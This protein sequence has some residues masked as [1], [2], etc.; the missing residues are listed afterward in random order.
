MYVGFMNHGNM[1]QVKRK[2]EHKIFTFFMNFMLGDEFSSFYRNQRS[3][4]VGFMMCIK[5]LQRAFST[6]VEKLKEKLEE[7][8]EKGNLILITF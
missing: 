1:F 5:I 8:E 2:L 4:L 6:F 3:G 7:D